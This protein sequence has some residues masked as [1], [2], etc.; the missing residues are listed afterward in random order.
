MPAIMEMRLCPARPF[1]PTTRQLHGLACAVFEGA[2][3]HDYRY[4]AAD[5]SPS[6]ALRWTQR[7]YR[8]H[9][10]RTWGFRSASAS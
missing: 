1:E 9:V 3:I 2:Y 7:R 10:L 8:W 6:K 4:W 5:S